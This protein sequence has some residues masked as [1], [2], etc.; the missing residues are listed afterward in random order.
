MDEQK[1]KPE[2][3]INPSSKEINLLSEI[4][5]KYIKW[6]TAINSPIPIFRGLNLKQYLNYSRRLFWSVPDD[7]IGILGEDFNKSEFKIF[8][9]EIRNNLLDVLSYLLSLRVKPALEVNADNA[10]LYYNYIKKVAEAIYTNW[11]NIT[12]DKI[13]KF[14][15]LL[16]LIEN[17]TLIKYV[18]YEEIEDTRTYIK[19]KDS[20]YDFVEKKVKVK[21]EVV[22]KRVPLQR[23]LVPK[24][25]EPELSKQGEVMLI[26]HL[27]MREFK[28]K[29]GK[30]ERSKYVQTGSRIDNDSIYAGII[31][32]AT[33][34]DKVEV[35]K[36]FDEIRDR[37]VIFA[38]GVWLNPRTKGNEQV[39]FPLP[40][41]HKKLPFEKVIFEPAD[42]TFFYGLSLPFKLRTPQQLYN[43]YNELLVLR[44]MKEI[45]PP[46]LT[47]DI[48]QN[49]ALKFGPEAVIPVTDINEWKELTINPASGSF[50]NTLSLL[51]SNLQPQSPVSPMTSRQPRSA[52][53]KK[54]E[55]YRK[56]QF[57]ENYVRML[58]DL[59]YQEIGLVVKTALQ[60][61]P[62]KKYPKETTFYKKDIHKII[63]L[64][65]ETL[66]SGGVGTLEVRLTPEP[67]NYEK[68]ALESEV[69]GLLSK[70][71]MEIIEI[72]PEVLDD[73]DIAVTAVQLETEN[74]PAM[75]EA[76]FKEKLQFIFQAF[77]NMISPVKAMLRT[78][79]V[80]K[81]SPSDWVDP[82]VLEKIYSAYEEQVGLP[83]TQEQQPLVQAPDLNTQPQ[84]QN[85]LQ[86]IRG[87]N[88]GAKG[89]EQNTLVNNPEGEPKFGSNEGIPIPEE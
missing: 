21:D 31:P 51:K 18:G 2:D 49:I 4:Y 89:G 71:K 40:Y 55:T 25:Q 63:T 12:K 39:E 19:Y 57:Y 79:E 35:V 67:E 30:F 9:P 82:A 77:G 15:D 13:E 45:S 17:G 34:S 16:Y 27:P 53:E 69:R 46:I 1:I 24:L 76:L 22:A 65:N 38:N 59:F 37:Y 68:L 64:H 74:P 20:G 47:S 43:L 78:F 75:E 33:I 36:Y 62:S 61:Y 3:L 6:N 66:P 50:F 11:R 8:F 23:F 58:W 84:T 42:A 44:E 56:S 26:E 86:A 54:I 41:N 29:Y 52:T 70:T 32:L 60:F 87:M 14:W 7:D 48:E 5:D 72:S 80:L 88:N 81:E 83:Q 10:D 85:L 28:A 73:I